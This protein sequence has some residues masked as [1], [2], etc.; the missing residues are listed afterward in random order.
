MFWPLFIRYLPHW[1]HMEANDLQ[2]ARTPRGES[3]LNESVG[4]A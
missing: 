4:Q 2:F 3:P 1:V